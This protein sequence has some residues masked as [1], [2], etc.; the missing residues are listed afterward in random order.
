MASGNSQ[1]YWMKMNFL[2]KYFPAILVLKHVSNHKSRR[3][4]K[5]KNIKRGRQQNFST[6]EDFLLISGYLNVSQDPIIGNQQKQDAFW[7][8]V[9]EYFLRD[10]NY[11]RTQISISSRWGLINKD[12]TKFVGCYAQVQQKQESGLTEQD[13]ILKAKELFKLS[14][15]RNFQFLHCWNV[16]KNELRWTSSSS[17]QRSN[18]SSKNHIGTSPASSSPATPDSVNLGDDNFENSE[19]ERP[20]GTKGAK[21]KL[22]KKKDKEHVPD[23]S[24][25]TILESWKNE[26]ADNECRKRERSEKQIHIQ[27]E[28]IEL[29]NK[30]REDMIMM[31]DTSD[32]DETRVSYFNKLQEKILLKNSV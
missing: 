5:K 3:K 28:Y 2:N 16:L 6:D 26:Y 7:K 14:T 9:H 19:F 24:A 29:E 15:K 30:R 18:K 8:R 21:E 1:L 22:K 11:D 4:M 27:E 12:V 31:T 23:S 13:R 20:S 25:A 17:S 32:M 10:T